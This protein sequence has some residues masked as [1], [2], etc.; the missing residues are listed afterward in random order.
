MLKS[1]LSNISKILSNRECTKSE[2]PRFSAKYLF[3]E[4]HVAPFQLFTGILNHRVLY[5][6]DFIGVVILWLS[7]DAGCLA[8]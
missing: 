6:F 4:K 3:P 7:K 5:I 1:R 2:V 8:P